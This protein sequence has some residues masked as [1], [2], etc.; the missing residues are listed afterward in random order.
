MDNRHFKKLWKI[1]QQKEQKKQKK[2]LNKQNRAGYEKNKNK[3][4]S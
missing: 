3:R 1:I 2:P 4:K